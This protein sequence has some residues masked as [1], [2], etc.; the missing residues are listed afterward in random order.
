MDKLAHHKIEDAYLKASSVLH[1]MKLKTLRGGKLKL[2]KTLEASVQGL[3]L[4]MMEL[5]K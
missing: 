2:M 5:R 3:E 4:V 1:A